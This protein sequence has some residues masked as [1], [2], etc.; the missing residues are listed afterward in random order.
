MLKFA[1][2]RI[3]T[4]INRI[5]WKILIVDD[6]VEVHNI[7]KSVLDKL[8]FEGREVE[9]ISAYSG[10]EAI[11]ILREQPD[12]SLILLDVVMETDDAGLR[13]VKT[14]RE[15]LNN[16]IVRIILRTGQP[17]SAPEK[18]IIIDYDINDYKEKTELT[19]NKLFTSVVAALR[20]IRD[21]KTIEYTKL[22]FQ[23]IVE[24]S[25]SI[26]KENSLLLF[27]EGILIQLV[28]IL[29]LSSDPSIIKASDAFLSMYK[30]G[31]FKVVAAA[32]KFKNESIIITKSVEELL[33]EAVSEKKNFYKNDSYLGFFHSEKEKILILYIEGISTLTDIDKNLLE[34]F[35]HNVS[36]AFEN[37]C[38]NQELID[39]QSEIVEKLGE[40]I[41]N[42]SKETANHIKRVAEISYI[43][44]KA[45]GLSEKEANIIK[46]ASP[47]HDVGKIAI[48][49][50]ILL[51]PARLIEK[52]FTLMKSHAEVG[53]KILKNSKREILQAS[54]K[55]AHDHHEKWEGNGY[56]RGLKGEN[57]SLYGRITAVADVFDALTQKRV[58]KEAW[59][60]E[61]VIEL[62]REERGKHFE[63]KLVDLL[64]DNI[65][66]IKNII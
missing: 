47:M 19:S 65:E 52:E 18:K 29:N 32:G 13:A 37:I 66:N 6:E 57:I 43:L 49:D 64:L 26:L 14:I 31:T 63:P 34:V 39:T 50:N 36:A 24:S 51:K 4:I 20:S 61:Q 27:V 60:I 53:W 40:V 9:F 22:G 3:S 48:P 56:P 62:F 17:G 35:S 38:L 28:S 59:P 7:T 55:I 15:E 23:K 11:K 30:K 54:A 16:K 25:R 12:I 41:E 8:E 46:F 10:H 21:L 44:A 58:Y 33:L 2:E 5:K 45:Y 42:R 1:E